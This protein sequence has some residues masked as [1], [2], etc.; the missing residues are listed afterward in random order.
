MVRKKNSPGRQPQEV[1]E[2]EERSRDSHLNRVL[3]S[4]SVQQ[5]EIDYGWA[6]WR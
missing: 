4:D 3:G 1:R 2:F 5:R 6:A